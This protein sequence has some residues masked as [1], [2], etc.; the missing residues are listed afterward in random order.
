MT[1]PP[2]LKLGLS[3]IN[4]LKKFLSKRNEIASIYK[5]YLIDL[6][7]KFQKIEKYN[8][9]SYHL[10][11]VQFDLSK[12]KHNYKQ[13]FKR[14]R[15]KNYYVNLHYMPLH[16]SSYFKKKGFKKGQFPVSEKY[17]QVSISIPI[18]FDLKKKDIFKF[19]RL[20]RSFF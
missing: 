18:F 17:G 9:S 10:L 15:E 11:V 12:T 7:I 16:L 1:Y 2:Q 8:Y 5:R 13:I 20:V 14:M 3:Q 4:R 6:P 19:C